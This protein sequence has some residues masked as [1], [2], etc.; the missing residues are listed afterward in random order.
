MYGTPYSP[1]AF[2]LWHLDSTPRAMC[3]RY[4]LVSSG[5]EL[6]Q[7]F[8]VAEAPPV[9]RYNAAPLQFLPVIYREAGQNR[10]DFFRWGLTPAWAA[11]DFGGRLINAR[12]ESLRERPS[13][14][15]LLSRRRCL[16]PATAF[17][18]WLK[19]PSGRFPFRFFLPTEPLFALAGLW[20]EWCNP[21]TG[22]LLRSFAI[23]TVPANALVARI[24]D[25]MPAVL[26]R[27]AEHLW[28]HEQ[29]PVTT[30]LSCLQP[31]PAD[32]MAYAPASR[33]LN[34]P[35]NDDASVLAPDAELPEPF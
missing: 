12:A 17:Y 20:D 5:E 31:Y 27:Q 25:R 7:R 10:L 33:R 13:F 4:M 21:E 9:E 22:E 14:R 28:L 24:H 11:E 6:S 16:V 29:T 8:Q 34:H 1:V 18:E 3:G 15:H 19:H 32:S 35:Q 26:T 30:A 2:R 23:V